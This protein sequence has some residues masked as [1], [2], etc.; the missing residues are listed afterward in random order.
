IIDEQIEHNMWVTLVTIHN[1]RK[2]HPI[3]EQAVSRGKEVVDREV[4]NALFKSGL[5]WGG[6]SPP[7]RPRGRMPASA[8][9]KRGKGGG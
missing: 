8:L 7:D 3:M 4:E 2:K 5:I 6:G 1:C 9:K